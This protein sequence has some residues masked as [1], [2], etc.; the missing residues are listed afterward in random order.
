MS[1]TE[2][3]KSIVSVGIAADWNIKTYKTALSESDCLPKEITERYKGYTIPQDF[4]LFLSNVKSCMFHDESVWIIT[5]EDYA[6][7]AESEYR[8]NEFEMMDV[9][10]LE[11]DKDV[12]GAAEIRKW[13]D[14]HLPICISVASG[15]SHYAIDLKDGS[16]VYG[17]EPDFE[18]VEH[19]ASSFREFMESGELFLV[20]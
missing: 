2:W 19:V 17:Y 16:V 13:W 4:I 18:E 5:T 20:G 1:K 7:V 12:E 11:R 8:W 6:G 3:I 15:F 14:R 9:E 10:S